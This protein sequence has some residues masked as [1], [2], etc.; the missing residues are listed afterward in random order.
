MSKK[1][2]SQRVVVVSFLVD[3]IDVVTNLIVA[4]ITGSAT[5]FSEMAQGVADSIGS[6]FLV[7]GERRSKK[8]KD[9]NHPLGYPRE[10]FF[11]SLMSAFVMLVIGGG[12][13][14]YRGID[15]LLNPKPLES[16]YLAIIVIVIAVFTN[17]YAVSLSARNLKSELGSLKVI[18]KNYN[19]PLVK[20]AF[21]RDVVGTTTSILGLIAIIAY[22]LVE[23]PLFDAIGAIISAIL[24]IASSIFLIMQA[25]ALIT[26]QA[27]PENEIEALKK[28]ILADEDVE[29]VNSLVAIYSG[30]KE[31]LIEA[32]LDVS[33]QLTTTQIEELLDDLEER[34]SKQFPTIDRV[35]V[36]LNSPENNIES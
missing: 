32:D 1:I 27:L 6:I 14:L 21:L 30:R 5:V 36:L 13:S 11:W 26:G 18:F 25:R 15:Q 2:S 34:I 16:P 24:M 29:A 35:R 8:K 3:V 10:S 12:L 17:G 22:Q 31:I 28:V 4:Y 20:G 33:E 19:H 23:L 7:I 9:T